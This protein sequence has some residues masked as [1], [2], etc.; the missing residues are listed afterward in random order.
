[1]RGLLIHVKLIELKLCSYCG[2]HG[3]TSISYFD[4]HP[5]SLYGQ[6]THDSSHCFQKKVQKLVLCVANPLFDLFPRERS[7]G[8]IDTIVVTYLIEIVPNALSKAMSR[9][10]E[11]PI[12]DDND[13]GCRHLNN[14]V[15]PIHHQGHTHYHVITH[16]S[17]R[18]HMLSRYHPSIT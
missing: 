8:F 12:S 1:M 2:H 10:I 5:C 9:V 18:T 14:I 15:S 11:A 4:L 3:Y 7:Y 6:H 13:V 17:P 16:S